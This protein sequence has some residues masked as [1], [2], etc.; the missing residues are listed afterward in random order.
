MNSVVRRHGGGEVSG[1]HRRSW[2]ESKG[3]L[4]LKPLALSMDPMRDS[5]VKAFLDGQKF[6]KTE[7]GI[8]QDGQR[9]W[10]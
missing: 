6:K 4:A 1:G 3:L 10:D 8:F 2:Y 5:A 7:D 9:D